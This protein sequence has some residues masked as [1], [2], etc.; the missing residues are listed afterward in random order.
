MTNKILALIFL[1]VSLFCLVTNSYADESKASD[2][3]IY[4][5]IPVT[6]TMSSSW[7]F[8]SWILMMDNGSYF[9]DI[10]ELFT[11]LEIPYT[12][13]DGGEIA[14]GFI[15]RENRTYKI[16]F[17]KMEIKYDGEK[18]QLEK[19]S[20]IDAGMFYLRDDILEEIFDIETE[21]KIRDLSLKLSA[22][23]ELPRFKEMRL[24]EMRRNIAK[25]Q[26]KEFIADTVVD[27]N[28]KLFAGS[29]LD[30][31]ASAT[32]TTSG[33]YNGGLELVYGS[34]FLWGKFTAGASLAS[35]SH[36]IPR[37]F[38]YN[39]HWVNNDNPIARQVQLGMI[40]LN[41]ALVGLNITNQ[42]TELREA[43]GSYEHTGE[44]ES[45]WTVEL[46][47]NGKLIDYQ[48]AD[49]SGFYTFTVPFV[50]GASAVQ[51]ISYGPEGQERIEER[52]VR[53][54]YTMMMAKSF[55]YDVSA[56][57]IPTVVTEES[58]QNYNEF[59]YLRKSNLMAAPRIVEA[60]M[61]YGITNKLTVSTDLRYQLIP[62]SANKPDSI[63][64]ESFNYGAQLTYNFA[65][66]ISMSAFNS[67][68][69]NIGGGLNLSLPA[70]TTVS[71]NYNHT[72]SNKNYNAR[73]SISKSYRRG[74][75][76]GIVRA[77]YT[78]TGDMH[79]INGHFSNSIKRF[80]TSI[81]Y[82]ELRNRVSTTVQTGQVSL[83]YGFG[84]A[85]ISTGCDVDFILK[86]PLSINS[87]FNTAVGKGRLGAKFNRNIVLESNQ[88][89]LSYSINFN[90]V[91]TSVRTHTVDDGSTSFRERASGGIAFS[92]DHVKFDRRHTIN[93][94]GIT[95][96]PYLD[97]NFNNIYDQG[98]T[99][100]QVPVLSSRVYR[101]SSDS[102][103]RIGII[104]AHTSHQI[105][106]SNDYLDYYSWQFPYKKW[107]VD[108]DPHQYK[109]IDVPIHVFGE[110][111]GSVSY[112]PE[113]RMI[114]PISDTTLDFF[115]LDIEED[116]PDPA[117]EEILKYE[118]NMPV[119]NPL[120]FRKYSYIMEHNPNAI[121]QINL[122]QDE[123]EVE[124]GV[125]AYFMKGII[126]DLHVEM[127]RRW[128]VSIK[129][130]LI[131]V[132]G[133]P[134][135]NIIIGTTRN[136][137]LYNNPRFLK[138]M[139]RLVSISVTQAS[140]IPLGTSI[141]SEDTY[142]TILAKE[143][144]SG[145]GTGIMVEVWN[146]EN[147]KVAE[148]ST[149]FDGFFSYLGLRPGEYS[150]TV[151]EE[152]LNELNLRQYPDDRPVTITVSEEGDYIQNNNFILINKNMIRDMKR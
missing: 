119:L 43:T 23:F 83:G 130:Y 97:L 144:V 152:K 47:V 123:F 17:Q 141:T 81:S 22:N 80:N 26:G 66:W 11:N 131:D 108:V 15:E 5:E 46:Y 137:D 54:P 50:Y 98:D 2:V 140:K 6:V 145:V 124:D 106:F 112:I 60:D 39:W 62:Y 32:Q 57:I 151:N 73:A 86:E 9:I 126:Y 68:N 88:Y 12:E 65:S 114:N 37:G 134:E 61:R 147:E 143:R 92:K 30:W 142:E 64:S 139:G 94:A 36:F 90:T 44:T 14:T 118:H 28:R 103:S 93:G 41:N 49:A 100:I 25:I 63:S 16:D 110:A 42:S 24:E 132:Q 111:T 48:I 84:A 138:H 59:L 82:N 70:R 76:G 20:Y 136:D 116:K 96:H 109:N 85:A 38:L 146:N 148:T 127:T 35:H 72:L 99:T 13:I 135:E 117:I 3:F 67:D 113:Y 101:N 31:T 19:G 34:E 121:F 105:E 78:S 77:Q 128:A 133:V 18:H 95:L 74:F 125:L 29:M 1:I 115:Y 71:M 79:T 120:A 51:V 75:V 87:S 52:N 58:A 56:G 69:K 27:R 89:S 122:P 33:I 8:E 150:L 45:N 102:L 21:F 129:Q 4:E 149:E 40:D 55:Q 91:K 10:K 7:G 53:A 104:Q 107:E